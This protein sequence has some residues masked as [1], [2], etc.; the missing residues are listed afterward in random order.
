LAQVVLVLSAQ[1]LAVQQVLTQSLQ[2]LPQQV[3]AVARVKLADK[4]PQQVDRVV[5]E[6][7]ATQQEQ[8]VTQVLILQ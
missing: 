4:L 2:P 6:L 7:I 8:Q 5:E 3:A 1:A